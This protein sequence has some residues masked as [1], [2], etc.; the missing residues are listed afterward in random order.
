MLLTRMRLIHR[1][2]LPAL[3]A[4][5]VAAAA[6]AQSVSPTTGA[7]RAMQLQSA[8][9]TFCP[10]PPNP[11]AVSAA[12][13]LCMDCLIRADVQDVPGV[14]L[15][16]NVLPGNDPELLAIPEQNQFASRPQM[17]GA[18]SWRPL[19]IRPQRLGATPTLSGPASSSAV[20]LPALAILASTEV[21]NSVSLDFAYASTLDR[22]LS[23]AR[24]RK[25]AEE[26]R[27]QSRELQKDLGEQ[28]RQLH[29]SDLEC[30]LKL[31]TQ[32][33]SAIGHTDRIAKPRQQEN[34]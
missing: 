22:K 9:S 33:L 17:A 31:R 26:Q 12:V 4:V 32:K 29:L 30:R 23:R 19:A 8:N 14:R 20:Q 21:D 16:Q 27:R 6:L 3:L 28:C 15:D 2:S 18:T 10:E 1:L 34:R 5:L 24:S 7:A 11:Q 13:N 25:Q